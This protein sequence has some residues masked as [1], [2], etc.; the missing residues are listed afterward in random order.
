[1]SF[2]TISKPM[3]SV[4]VITYNHVR[5]IRKTLEGVLSQQTNFYFEV[6]IGEDSSTDGTHEIA[7][8]YEISYPGK[9]RVITHH[10][11]DV[12]YVNG[13]PTGRW[14][15]IDTLAKATGKYIAFVEGDDYWTDPLKLQKQVDLMESRPDLI[16]CGHWCINVDD[17]D[18]LLAKQFCTGVGVAAEFS[19]KQALSSTVLHPNTWLFRNFDLIN[20]PAYLL[21]LK[22]PAADD[23]MCLILLGQGDGYCIQEFM[24]AYRI[25]EGGTWSTKSRLRKEF[26]MLQYQLSAT[27]LVRNNLLPEIIWKSTNSLTRFAYFFVLDLIKGNGNKVIPELLKL[28]R[29]QTTLSKTRVIIFS[30]LA[31]ALFPTNLSFFV[32][33]KARRIFLKLSQG[34]TG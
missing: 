23:P 10:R 12:I 28:M 27:K 30:A 22:L 6:L 1:M 2:Q 34:L 29:I 21:L 24:S 16:M 13:N 26:E 9:V 8:E 7:L 11:K 3:V 14:N 4:C 17:K 15:Y 18:E 32:V 5:F 19:A 33:R 31:L 25:H 20:H